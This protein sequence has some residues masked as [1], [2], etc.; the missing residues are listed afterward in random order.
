MAEI[1][2]R[3]PSFDGINLALTPAAA[4]DTAKCGPGYTLLVNNGGATPLTVTLVVPGNTP[5]GV[6]TP[7][8]AVTIPAG[9]M[10]AI[11]LLDVYRDPSTRQAAVNWSATTSVTRVV[12]K[13]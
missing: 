10:W 12:I 5:Y 3:T 6:A 9:Q 11:P 1:P 7:D 2:V 8:K 4:S 13:R